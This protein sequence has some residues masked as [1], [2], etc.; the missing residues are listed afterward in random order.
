[1]ICYLGEE[2]G[3]GGV[4]RASLWLAR[5]EEQRSWWDVRGDLQLTVY[6]ECYEN[7]VGY[8]ISF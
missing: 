3:I 7:Q 2:N 4:V 5:E 8:I 1:M 6:A